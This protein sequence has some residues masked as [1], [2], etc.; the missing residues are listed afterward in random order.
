M[1]RS[2]FKPRFSLF[3]NSC[4]VYIHSHKK[5]IT[6]IKLVFIYAIIWLFLFEQLDPDFGWHLTSGLYILNHGIPVKD[7]FSY[8]ASNFIWINHEWGND[9]I[10][11]FLYKLG[12]IYLLTTFFALIWAASICLFRD[13]IRLAILLPAVLAYLNFM[14]FRPIAFTLLFFAIIISL[15]KWK[16]NKLIYA[17]PLLF[18]FWANLH[19]GFILGLAV[20][21]YFT[22]QKKS[23][24]WLLIF[25]LSSLA[26]LIN[27]YGFNLYIEVYQTI[28][29]N[30]LHKYI[31]EWKQFAI[32][33]FCYLFYLIWLL[34]FA[35][36]D[37]KNIKK[38]LGLGFLF[39]IFSFAAVRNVPLFVVAA[40][41]D[42]DG[43]SSELINKKYSKKIPK[44][45][46]IGY[47]IIIAEIY[48]AALGN[49][50]FGNVL[51]G[52]PNEAINYLKVHQ[53]RGNLFNSYNYGGYLI[54]KLPEQKIFIAGNMTTWKIPNQRSYLSDY[55]SVL[56]NGSFQKQEFK[57]YNI[58]C[59]L[60][61]N[62][63]DNINLVNDLKRQGWIEPLNKTN[64]FILLIKK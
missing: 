53:C 10:T 57:K 44:L 48:F 58:T 4:L 47:F 13:R 20:I 38:Y 1:F 55:F 5:L 42:L 16:N 56:N 6:I 52:Y 7:P 32:P 22:I 61:Q 31:N 45:F 30:E 25:L 28:S 9:V 49:T 46:Y 62:S 64:G 50:S 39:F 21:L 23:K 43:Y 2:V 17:L 33:I 8:T 26:V 34:G 12:G 3:Y 14:Q 27:P 41:K 15:S 51:S 40:L 18:I 36:F 24:L 63:Q 60:V 37:L 11:A 59:V 35:I 29:D 19:G 54:W